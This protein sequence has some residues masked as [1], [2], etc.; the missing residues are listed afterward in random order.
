MR[1][2]KA[3]PGFNWLLIHKAQTALSDGLH[4]NIH[5]LL[6]LHTS[7]RWTKIQS[8]KRQRTNTLLHKLVQIALSHCYVIQPPSLS[9]QPADTIDSLTTLISRMHAN[10]SK[11]WRWR[12]WGE[13]VGESERWEER[14]K[15]GRKTSVMWGKMLYSCLCNCLWMLIPTIVTHHCWI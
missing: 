6:W 9:A 4:Y 13:N 14:K 3:F 10:T 5:S 15:E 12:R 11:W 8:N 2:V 1:E 7:E